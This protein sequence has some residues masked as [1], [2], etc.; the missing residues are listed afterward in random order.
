M[1]A[2]PSAS[3]ALSPGGFA[4]SQLEASQATRTIQA[5]LG[6]NPSAL[7]VIFSH[8]TLATTDP[9]YLD[10][11]DASLR[12]LRALDMVARVTTHRDNPRQAAPDGHTAYAMISLRTVPDEFRGIIP[13][14]KAAFDRADS[15]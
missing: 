12:D 1:P 10:A 8:P 3:R 5:A 13:A 4:T 14:S 11:V 9:A 7:L 15:R 6:E 2:A